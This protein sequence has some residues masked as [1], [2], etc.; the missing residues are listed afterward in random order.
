MSARSRRLAAFGGTA[1]PIVFVAVAIAHSLARSDHSLVARPI[2]ALSAGGSGWVQDANFV[3]LGVAL[4]ALAAGLHGALPPARRP[5]LGT[6]AL[7]LSGTALVLVGLVPATDEA[8]AFRPDH[9]G[10][11][12]LSVLVFTSAAVGMLAVARRMRG[13]PYWSAGAAT[14]RAA[15][16]GVAVLLPVFVALGGQPSAPLQEWAGLLQWALVAAWLGGVVSLG[17]RLLGVD[18]RAAWPVVGGP[19]PHAPARRRA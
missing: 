3:V 6:G 13:D 12:A 8:G 15:G 5:R 1:A 10:H 4:T 9:P 18:R 17:S 2:S 14:A 7:A 16:I 19:R 11:G